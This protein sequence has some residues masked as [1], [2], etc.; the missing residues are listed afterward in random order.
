MQKEFKLSPLNTTSKTYT[1]ESGAWP[2][3]R[4][5]GKDERYAVVYNDKIVA[6]FDNLYWAKKFDEQNNLAF[7]IMKVDE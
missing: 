3:D 6:I 5:F 4:D 2:G 1:W 7:T